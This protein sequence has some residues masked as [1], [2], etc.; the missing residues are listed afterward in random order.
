MLVHMCRGFLQEVFVVED[1]HDPLPIA[2]SRL[3]QG[4]PACTPPASVPVLHMRL[5]HMLLCM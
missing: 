5:C 4:L 1:H 3:S 2:G